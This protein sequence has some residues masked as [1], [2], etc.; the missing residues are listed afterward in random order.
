MLMPKKMKYRK[1]HRGR[2]RGL[3]FRGSELDFGDFGLKSVERN[4][5][6]SREIEAARRALTRYIRR[7]G[8]VWIR[9]FPDHAV[10]KQ[11]AETRMGGG[12]GALDHFVAVVRPGQMIFELAGVTEL[13]AKEALRL[14][15]HKLSVKTIMMTKETR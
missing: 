5:V 4:W 14:A 1:H 8:Q 9:V 12:K 6:T 7:G 15:A 10:T 11:P 13:V 3:A 2:M